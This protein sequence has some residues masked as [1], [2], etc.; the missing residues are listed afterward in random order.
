MY[1]IFDKITESV[2]SPKERTKET[3]RERSNHERN[4]SQEK[5][6]SRSSGMNQSTS[7][8]SKYDKRS[9]PGTSVPPGHEWSEHISSHGKVY[10]YN[11]LTEVS[12]WDKP[13]DFDLRRTSSKDSSYSSR[14][15]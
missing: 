9:A 10:Y 1:N 7:R 14:S 13:R 3:E 5:K 6:G 12:Q 15:S 11:C 4:E 8:S 2:R